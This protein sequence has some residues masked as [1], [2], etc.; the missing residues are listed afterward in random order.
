MFAPLVAEPQGLVAF[1]TAPYLPR[2]AMPTE[3]TSRRDGTLTSQPMATVQDANAPAL[4]TL[5]AMSFTRLRRQLY[6]DGLRPTSDK[7]ALLSV[8]LLLS[9]QNGR[10]PA[11]GCC[12]LPQGAMEQAIKQQ[13]LKKSGRG[14][15]R[16][17][18]MPQ[19]RTDGPR[20][21]K[22]ERRPRPCRRRV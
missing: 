10:D 16:L 3:R 19:P 8:G 2:R 9:K 21:R 6:A 5:S 7:S 13:S 22:L 18:A 1:D 4:C 20:R 15:A 17:H 14:T 11:A 12:A